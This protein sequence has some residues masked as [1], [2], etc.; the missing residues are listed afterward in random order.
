MKRRIWITSIIFCINYS[1]LF[2][3]YL[4]KHEAVSDNPSIKIYVNKKENWIMFNI[5]TGYYLE[6]LMPETMKLL[7]STKSR[8]TKDKNGENVPHL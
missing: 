6:L 8:I 2:W 3:I 5:K 1:R 4:K 7:G